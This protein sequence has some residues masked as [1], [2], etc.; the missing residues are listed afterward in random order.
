MPELAEIETVVNELRPRLLGRQIISTKFYDKPINV[1]PSKTKIIEGLQFARVCGLQRYGKYLLIRI[2]KL[3]VLVFHLGMSGNL[4]LV[5]RH[6]LMGSKHN[7]MEV[8]FDNGFMLLYQDP[9]RFGRVG[10]GSFDNLI[11]S[12]FMPKLGID[13]LEI[14]PGQ[15]YSLIKG[16]SRPVKALLMDQSIIS[17]VG[18]IYSDE[19]LF[20]AGI[21][22]D[23]RC[24]DLTFEDVCIL[25]QMLRKVLIQGIISKG[26]SI[27]NF[28]RPFGE[29]GNFQ[30]LICVY[31]RA[32]NPCVMCGA[33]LISIK[34]A[35]RTSTFCPNC[36]R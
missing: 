5:H 7:H 10:L 9:R 15:L 25:V 19:A 11:A 20:L 21:R 13:A 33:K 17:G 32:G 30:E 2:D 29:R 16:S 18:N 14:E 4:R 28:V 23:K 24:C 12:G 36:Q 26:C 34:V 1:F 8:V 22:P 35:G 27:K 6:E 31:G 3:N